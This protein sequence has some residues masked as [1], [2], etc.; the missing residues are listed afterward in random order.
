MSPVLL[1]GPVAYAAPA[2]A[3]SAP[4]SEG[5]Q[6]LAQAQQSGERVEVVG[7][8]SERTTV[9]ANPDG[10]TFTLEESAVPV[11]VAAAGGDWQ[12][13]DATLE[14]R[15][16]GSVGPKAAAVRMAFSGGGDK[17]P[18]ARIADA[19]RSLELGWPGTL[20]TPRLE[21]TSALY[22]DVLPGVDLKVNATPESFQP[23]FVVKTPEAAASDKLKKLTFGLKAEGLDVREGPSGNL[24]AVDGSGR[25]VFRAPPA[26]M[27][28][29]TGAAS[30]PQPQLAAAVAGAA[31]A[32]VGEPSDPSEAAPS[33]SGVQ[34]GQGDTVA[35]M[36]VEVTEDALSVVP[37]A[38][39]L[40][41][42]DA[43]AFPVFIDP[44]VTWGESERTLLRS[45]GYE[46]YGWGNGDDGQGKGAGKCGTWNGYYC[47]PGYVQKLYFEFSPSSLKGKHVLDATF[48][49]TEPWAFQCDPRW[50]D[51]VRTNNISSS[52]TWSTRPKELDL[53]VDR[54]VSAGRGSLCDPDSPDAPIEF[55][56]NP[57]ESNENL[58]PTVRDFAA[59]KFSRLTLEVK[60]HDESDT[61]AWKRF[62][63]DAV[64]S[65][66]Y[67]AVPATPTE[68]GVVTGSGYVCS[69][70]S[71]DPAVVSDPTPL[72]QG[73]PRTMPGGESGAN[74]RIRWRTDMYDGANWV[75]AHTDVDSPTSGYV[76][77][78]VKQTRS[79][80]TL[81]EGVKYRLKALTLSYY[82]DGTNRLNTGYTTPCYFTV[83]AT[84]PK[85]PQVTIGSPYTECTTNEC[86]ANGGP[87]VP[88][89][90]TFAPAAG[91]ANNVAYQYR[92]SEQDAWSADLS[93][94]TASAVITPTHA[95]THRLYVRAK[96]NVGRWGAEN[97][98]DFLVAAGEGPVGR[99]HF[100]EASGAALDSETADGADD[101]TLGGGA[102]R[103]DRGR[104][105]LITRDASGVPLQTPATDRGMVLD[106][107]S[108]YAA[109]SGPVLE[110]RSA[111]TLSAWVRL[112]RDDRKAAV[113]STKD[114]VSSPFLLYYTTT[115]KTWYFGIRQPGQ[116]DWYYGQ[117]AVFPAQVGVWTHLAGTYDPATGE[118]RFYVNGRLQYGAM[119]VE[120][121]YPSTAPLD[122][123]RHQFSTGPGAY[124]PGSID[125][126]SV[127][128]RALTSQ[129]ISDEARLLTAQQYAGV[130]L[131]A[132]WSAGQGSGN[133]VPDTTSGYGASLTLAGGASLDGESIVLD[134]VD[135]AATTA[136]PVVD[137]TGSFTVTALASLDGGTLAAK[138][139]GYTAQVLGQRTVDGSAWGFWYELTGKDTVLDE[140]TLEDKTV[141]VGKWHF[142]RLNA[143]G[144]FSAVISDDVAA[145]DGMVRLTGVFDAQ[146]GTI[147]LYLGGNPNN[148]PQAFTAETGSGDF[149]VGK[150]FNGGAWQYFLPG[151]VAEVRLWAGAMAGWEQVGETVGD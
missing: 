24:A 97:V 122:F 106:G 111:F 34:P 147:S 108:A 84:A 41:R 19:G 139:I 22:A 6:A 83:D 88:G 70:N 45:D 75:L 50:V 42:T 35:R 74:L 49:V 69:T 143:D 150:G 43:S 127:W 9:Y 38:A 105:G 10:Y 145:V 79:L 141:P 39:M 117:Y 52:T 17:A 115:Q 28:D 58:T 138:D 61:S 114:S 78:L 7:E 33:G 27:W 57:D 66:K 134:G 93:G 94:S 36:D 67:V 47:G 23:V 44:T 124:F 56:D 72:V 82:E 95:G 100:S 14:Q 91:D 102:V 129:E 4:L 151:R 148:A 71:A 77:N 99:W 128:Q 149:A 137:D 87:S 126:V 118:L 21:G 146:A 76:G 121:S 55:H 3:D 30:V 13:P 18:L 110:T 81:Q 112:E 65:V 11:R 133:S 120:G 92:L 2:K 62:K 8:R 37:D 25:T 86:V 26:R 29:S 140:E 116:T 132:D 64:L 107:T 31:A 53:M 104:R 123:G 60:A 5:R 12:A 119:T 51:L 109:T 46:S 73:R 136:G 130:E 96:D 16:D 90:F 80:P 131:V 15:S 101:A 32:G 135:G 144:T 20:P 40:A 59:G 68:V 113:L 1:P 125:E 142:G 85:A 48:R 103:D 98:I 54:N 89:T 63:N